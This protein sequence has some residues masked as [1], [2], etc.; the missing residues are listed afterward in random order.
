[1]KRFK[2]WDSKPLKD[3]SNKK[4]EINGHWSSLLP[5][6]EAVP[7]KL[8]TFLNP[9]S[10]VFETLISGILMD[11]YLPIYNASTTCFADSNALKGRDGVEFG[12]NF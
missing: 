3:V 10:I 4:A 8:Y 2:W 9:L 5:L 6:P 12:V 11:V 7:P 1:M